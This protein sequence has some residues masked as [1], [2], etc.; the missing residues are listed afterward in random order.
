VTF[1]SKSFGLAAAIAILSLSMVACHGQSPS[2]AGYVPMTPALSAQQGG[3]IVDPFGKKARIESACG[4]RLRIVIAGILSCRFREKGYGNG[5][6][7]IVNHESGIIGVTPS[8]G[9]RATKFTILGLVA[10]SGYFL[11]KN[12]KGD[13]YKVRVSVTL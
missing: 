7:T 12:T 9:T 10:G 4:H 2:S 11:V 5:T 1:I 6:F 8:S 3:G 13:R